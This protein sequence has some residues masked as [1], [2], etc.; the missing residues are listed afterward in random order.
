MIAKGESWSGP[1]I[2]IYQGNNFINVY[3]NLFDHHYKHCLKE[4]L[5]LSIADKSSNASNF[6]LWYLGITDPDNT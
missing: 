3:K 2:T 5:L 4:L 6:S 1:N